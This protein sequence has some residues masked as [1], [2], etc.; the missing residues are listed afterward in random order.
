M[1]ALVAINPKSGGGKGAVIG[2]KVRRQ[3]ADSMHEITFVEED[4]REGSL[5]AV[6]HALKNDDFELLIAVGGDGFIHDLLPLLLKFEI[7][8]LVA[9]AGT[10]NDIART[11]GTY[12]LKIAEI[13]ELPTRTSPSEINVGLISHHGEE[14]PFVQIL[15]TGFDAVV[16]ERAN[17]FKIIKGKNKYV[18]AVLE[19]IWKFKAIDFTI[20]IDGVKQERKAMLVCVANGTSYGAGMKIVPFAKDD[21]GVF[22]LMVVDQV[23]PLRLLMVFPRVFFGRHINH[24]KVHFFTGVDIKIAGN[25]E[26]FADGERIAK[27]P[28]HIK[29]SPRNLQVFRA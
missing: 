5:H 3:F 13:L 17:N 27:L 26:A 10:G 21:D 18:L 1:K 19:M 11:L 8:L 4:S 15:S 25:T 12:P 20:T 22:D 23:T 16:N 24:P 6:H 2:T 29:V 14:V 9:P 28:V 7:P